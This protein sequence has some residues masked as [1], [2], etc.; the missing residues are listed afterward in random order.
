MITRSLVYFKTLKTM[1]GLEGLLAAMALKSKLEQ[2]KDDDRLLTGQSQNLVELLAKY[3]DDN[4]EKSIISTVGCYDKRFLIKIG[5]ERVKEKNINKHK[6]LT[7]TGSGK[8][9]NMEDL[10]KDYNKSIKDEDDCD[11]PACMLRK[12]FEDNLN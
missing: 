4:K 7:I 5:L 6:G 9:L 1:K 8:E 11:C 12:S 10:I 3:L 2:I